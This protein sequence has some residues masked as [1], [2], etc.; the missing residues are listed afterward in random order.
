MTTS[1]GPIL[2]PIGFFAEQSILALEQ[3]VKIA[4]ITDSELF[5]LTVVEEPSTCKNYFL[6]TKNLKSN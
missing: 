3:A 2:V 4:K 1:T 5:L 6:V